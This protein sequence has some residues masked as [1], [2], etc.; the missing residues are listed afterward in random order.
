MG[1]R[2]SIPAVSVSSIWSNPLPGYDVL[3]PEPIGRRINLN[4]L[5][6]DPWFKWLQSQYEKD[7]K[8]VFKGLSVG[9]SDSM[10]GQAWYDPETNCIYFEPA[11]V[12]YHDEETVNLTLVHELTHAIQG[13]SKERWYKVEPIPKSIFNILYFYKESEI[14]AYSSEAKYGLLHGDSEAQIRE[15]LLT[16]CQECLPD[17]MLR[18]SEYDAYDKDAERWVDFILDRVKR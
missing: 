6:S 10:T 9:A 15:R 5:F 12:G 4:L 3:E 1:T 17:R 7:L 16:T 13:E 14:E 2:G 18:P 11:F 8:N